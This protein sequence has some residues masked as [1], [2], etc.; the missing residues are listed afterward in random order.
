MCLGDG[1]GEVS[2]GRR[3]F[4]GGAL[5]AL[6][7]S[8]FA[9]R[10]LGRQQPQQ[11]PPPKPAAPLEP[12]AL[13]DP[14]VAQRDFT[15]KSSDGAEMRA[16]LARPRR[17][18]RFPAVVVLSPN[19]RLTDDLRN[20]AAQLARGGFLALAFDP[21]S[22]DAGLTPDRARERFEYYG[23]REFDEVQRRDAASAIAYLRRQP[24]Y[25][26][27]PVGL[28]GFCGGGRRALI[29]AASSE[30]VAA[31]VAFYAP[32]VLSANFQ[33]PR[34]VFKLDVMD[35]LDR[36][37]APVQYHYGTADPFITAADVDR[38][39]RDLK[40]QGTPVEFYRYEGAT[41]A[42]YD[43]TRRHFHP[44]AAR[45]AHARMIQFFQKHLG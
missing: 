10:V 7:A 32:P 37:R 3:S 16:Y 35:V 38:L 5:R 13:G 21:Y 30:E 6:A 1:C 41:H 44:E 25:R 31:V 23:G 18:G 12:L 19:P 17:E 36:I 39:E 45:L 43:F 2:G 28:V 27:G 33:S 29:Y 22:R 15:F 40:A 26:R 14:A 4:L 24:F 8:A 20:T 42:F 9:S 34:G 11:P